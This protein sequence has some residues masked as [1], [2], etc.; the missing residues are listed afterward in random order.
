VNLTG[1]PNTWGLYPD[2]HNECQQ[3]IQ[4]AQDAQSGNTTVFSVAFASESDGCGVSASGYTD[5]VLQATATSGNPALSLS[6]LT[7]CIV[8]KNMASPTT[9]TGTSYFYADTSSQSS[10]CTDTAHS[11]SLTS[12]ADIFGA[13]AA[14][15]T[16]P[17]LL[18][19]STAVVPVS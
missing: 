18:P 4:A 17:R 12:I 15:F 9:A 14:T 1:S 10:G 2:F 13:I 11:A 8:M 6:T 16:T 19:S 7:P 5:T 3:A